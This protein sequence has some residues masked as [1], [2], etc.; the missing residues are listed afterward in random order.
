MI[1][2][3]KKNAKKKKTSGTLKKQYSNW[4][5]RSSRKGPGTRAPE[6]GNGVFEIATLDRRGS[7]GDRIDFDGN[8]SRSGEPPFWDRKKVDVDQKIHFSEPTF[9]DRNNP[10][11]PRDSFRGSTSHL[12]PKVRWC[13]PSNMQPVPVCS[14]GQLNPGSCFLSFCPKTRTWSMGFFVVSLANRRAGLELTP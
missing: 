2:P 11:N 5:P 4:K 13:P 3:F 10:M 9:W 1:F 14:L 8:F 7:F 12:F 6:P